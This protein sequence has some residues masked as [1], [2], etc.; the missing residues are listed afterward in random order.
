MSLGAVASFSLH[1]RKIQYL[2]RC[3]WVH[4]SLSLGELPTAPRWISL[5]LID[6]TF[7]MKYAYHDQRWWHR[8]TAS[9]QELTSC[10][11]MCLKPS[12]WGWYCAAMLPIHLFL[13]DGSVKEEEREICNLDFGRELVLIVYY[14]AQLEVSCSHQFFTWRFR[15]KACQLFNFKT[16]HRMNNTLWVLGS[17]Q[18]KYKPSINRHMLYICSCSFSMWHYSQSWFILSGNLHASVIGLTK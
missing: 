13:V 1:P 6:I 9:L 10:P 7:V 17:N 16:C 8:E 3:V 12:V 4:S 5:G 11:L 2:S 15:W 18:Q 14:R